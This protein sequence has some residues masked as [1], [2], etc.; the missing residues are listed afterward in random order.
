MRLLLSTLFLALH[1]SV[2][3]DSVPQDVA[4]HYGAKCLNGAPPTYDIT[5][6]VS[7]TKWVLFLEGGGWCQVCFLWPVGLA[8]PSVGRLTDGLQ[9]VW[10]SFWRISVLGLRG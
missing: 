6:N 1:G 4:D 8:G 7:S 2:S 9:C 5:R 3:A 10:L